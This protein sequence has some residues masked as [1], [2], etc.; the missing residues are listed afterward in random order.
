MMSSSDDGVQIKSRQLNI[1]VKGVVFAVAA[2]IMA[3]L[4]ALFYETFNMPP[5][6]LEGYPGDSFFPRLVLGFTSIWGAI[7]LLRGFVTSGGGGADERDRFQVHIGEFA[8][9]IILV[10][11]Y[12]LLMEPLGFEI[13]TFAF[14]FI[15]LVPRLRSRSAGWIAIAVATSALSTLILWA[16]FGLALKVQLPLMFLPL[17]IY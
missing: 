13:A 6:L 7:V 3:G 4:A 1:P 9:I 2:L 5:P 11:A 14:L 16:T 8:F 10:V 17:F 12:A 15:L